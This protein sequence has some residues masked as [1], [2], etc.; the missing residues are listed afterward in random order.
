MDLSLESEERVGRVIWCFWPPMSK[1]RCC[2]FLKKFSWVLIER[3]IF[4]DLD[5]SRGSAP[6]LGSGSSRLGLGFGR[7]LIAVISRLDKFR[8]VDLISNA[9]FDW[10][11]GP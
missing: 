5:S 7:L 6:D 11:I 8:S 1:N 4:L 9:R 3:L 10:M 2:W